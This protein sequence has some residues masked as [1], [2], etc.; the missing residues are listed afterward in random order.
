MP[1]NTALLP[2]VLQP[3]WPLLHLALVLPDM[4]AL[5]NHR[6]ENNGESKARERALCFQ[7]ADFLV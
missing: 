6:E 4:S 2:D 5:L 7:P 3:V 1:H